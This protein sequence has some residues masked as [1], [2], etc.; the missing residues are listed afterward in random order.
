MVIIGNGNVT[1]DIARIFLREI[2]ELKNTEIS[3][4]ALK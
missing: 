2:S 4:N 3:F 1:I